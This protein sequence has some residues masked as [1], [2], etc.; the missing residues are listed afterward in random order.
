MIF[1]GITLH[2]LGLGLAAAL[3]I[4]WCCLRAAR[5]GDGWPGICL[6]GLLSGLLAGGLI[7]FLFGR[8]ENSA[9]D[10]AVETVSILTVLAAVAVAGALLAAFWTPAVADLLA[11]PLTGIFDGGH[12]PPEPRPAYS[13]ARFQRK[14]GRARKAAELVRTQLEKFPGDFEGRGLLAEIQA[15]DL[16]DLPAATLTLEPFI[17]SPATPPPEA[18]AACMKLVNWHL[19]RGEPEAAAIH[20]KQIVV[21]FPNTKLAAKA[22]AQ[23]AVLPAKKSRHRLS[24]R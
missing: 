11:A 21:R 7:Y 16:D 18:F 4:G 20:L 13:A 19:Q 12:E 23:L 22:E 5:R 15:V 24:N 6:R 10:A 1:G 3:V 14:Q 17:N 2:H 8:S 9:G